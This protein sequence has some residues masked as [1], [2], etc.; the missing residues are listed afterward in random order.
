MIRQETFRRKLYLVEGDNV[1]PDIGTKV[2]NENNEEIGELRSSVDNIGL[3]LLNTQ[4]SHANF[5]VDGV[6][7]VMTLYN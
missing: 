5:Y 6:K 4:K 1:L 7:C 2:T 3:A